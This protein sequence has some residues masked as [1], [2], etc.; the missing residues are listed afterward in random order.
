MN[1]S[2]IALIVLSTLVMTN[3][4][5]HVSDS[6]VAQPK[7]SLYLSAG[8]LGLWFTGS[9][10]YERLVHTT[11]K[12]YHIDYFARINGGGF[13]TWGS[14]GPATTLSVQGV[15]GEKTSHFETGL[16]IAWLFDKLSYDIGV[17]N[18]NYPYPG[19]EPKPTIWEYSIFLPAVT[20]GYRYQKPNGRFLFRTGL[21]S[22][23]GVYLS[24]GTAF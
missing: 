22:P 4:R 12:K 16:G 19:S 6:V 9:L 23:E 2:Q 21:A 15:F 5:A 14:S 20:F 10:N 24:V 18:A 1:K 13:A 7:N 11:D 17:S 8:T 3:V